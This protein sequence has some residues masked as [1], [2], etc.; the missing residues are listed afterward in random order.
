MEL[1]AALFGFGA[2]LAVGI[3]AVGSATG[4]GRTAAAA[5]EAIARNPEAGGRIFISMLLALAFMEALTLFVFALVF[6]VQGSVLGII[7]G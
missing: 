1:A 4:Q 3:A 6:I 5:M 2:L 7:G